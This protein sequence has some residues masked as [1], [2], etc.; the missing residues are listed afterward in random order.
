MTLRL[1]PSSAFPDFPYHRPD[2][3]ALRSEFYARLDDFT[4]AE[5][6]ASAKDAMI[7]IDDIRARISTAAN[8]AH[9]RHTI[10]TRDTFYAA[11]KNWGDQHYPT[12]EAWKKDYYEKLLAS[13]HRPT[14][15]AEFGPQFFRIAELSLL[16]FRPEILPMLQRENQLSSEYVQL[17]ASAAIEVDGKTY[18]LSSIRAVAVEP[19][20]ERRR[21]AAAAQAEW[22]E[23][24]RPELDRI[25]SELTTT[26]QEAATALNCDNFTQ[27][28][29]ARMLRTDY[30][31][32]EVARFRQ[33]VVEHIVP[34]TTQLYER[35]RE[36]LGLD[37]LRYFDE[38]F[39]FPDGNPEPQGPPQ[40]ILD[41][42]REMYDALSPETSSFY[43]EMEARKLMDV[44]AQE[45][46]ATGGYC[47]LINDHQAPFIFSNF[48]GTSADIDVLTHEFGHAFQVSQSSTLRPMEYNWP[49]FEACEIHSMS[50]EFFTYPW[51]DKFFG[52]DVE[53]YRFSHLAGAL[54]FLPYGCAV[55]EFQH[56]VYDHPDCSAE[57]RHAAWR[58]IER[59]Y[60]P[61]RD[62][63][64]TPYLNQ[65]T[66]WQGQNHIFATP[67]YYIDYCLAQIC[68]F[69]FWQ[70]DRQNHELAWANYLKLCRAGGS[71]SFLE[72]VELADLDSPFDP[73]V[74]RRVATTVAEA[75]D[76]RVPK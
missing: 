29:Y 68:A 41:R 53:K 76:L 10:D 20:R 7:A 25:F 67:F 56:W 64:G 69:Q 52:E 44:V 35:Q 70:A 23:S 33:M 17:K 51:M 39:R 45:G 34:L 61:H 48:N 31:P 8:L 40:W 26:R 32:T 19:D 13:P 72:L 73:A 49:T 46:K 65:G 75:L 59:K 54:R 58:R 16:T 57:D 9:I 22:Y 14:L 37:K 21:K 15:E 50:M 55:D 42:A 27:L 11:E 3:D 2:L 4:A 1:G 28:G 24:K 63:E 30:G 71:H 18:N 36:R 43:R 12:T 62:Y 38:G 6:V 47:T 5:N 74:F 66:F 60:L